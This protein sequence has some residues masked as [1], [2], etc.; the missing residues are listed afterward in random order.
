L[1]DGGGDHGGGGYDGGGSYGDVGGSHAESVEGI[2]NI[3]GALDH[4]VGIDVAI[5][6]KIYDIVKSSKFFGGQV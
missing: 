2:G 4:S 5:T 1:G 3:A 6:W